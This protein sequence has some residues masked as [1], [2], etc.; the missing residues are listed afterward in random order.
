MS[1]IRHCGVVRSTGSRVFV[2]WRQLENDSRH[3]LVIYRDSLPEA[4]VTKVSDLVLNQGQSSIELWDVIDKIGTLE[5]ANMLTVLHKMGYIRKQSTLDIDM[6]VGGNNKIPLNILN[7][8]INS[9][10][11]MVAGTVKDFN[12]FK[13]QNVQYPEQNTVVTHLLDDANKYQQLANESFERAYNL[14]PSLRPQSVTGENKDD[15]L[16][17]LNID[18]SMSQAKAIELVKKALKE[19]KDAK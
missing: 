1:I 16:I 19:H 18:P 15:D 6:H 7:D 11:E 17:H 5:G 12:P 9:A 13:S 8:E 4:Y 2:V 10:P 3:C 14:D